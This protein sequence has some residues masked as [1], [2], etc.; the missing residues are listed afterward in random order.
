MYIIT[1]VL[2]IRNAIDALKIQYKMEEN[3]K[4]VKKQNRKVEIEK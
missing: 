2:L 1:Y 3:G 4:N